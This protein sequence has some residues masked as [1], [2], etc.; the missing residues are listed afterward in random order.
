MI[1]RL[2]SKFR[3][4]FH[5]LISSASA[6]VPIAGL[7]LASATAFA[8]TAEAA[9]NLN[10]CSL[11]EDEA[12]GL[13]SDLSS[14]VNAVQAYIDSISAMLH[15]ERFEQ[16]DCLADRARSNKER[17]PGGMW[18]IHE[19][20]KGL[21]DPAPDKHA[22]EN[23]WHDLMQLL[24]R[25]VETRPQSATARVALASAWIEYAGEARGTGYSNTVS[26]SGWKLYEDRTA[27]AEKT[28]QQA[29]TLKVR[30]PEWYVVMLNLA[31]NQSWEVKRLLALFDEALA[32]EPG[33]YYYGRA[34]AMLLEPKWSGEVGD[35][36]KFMEKVADQMGGEKGDAFYFQVASSK[37]VICGCEDQPQLSLERIER[38]YLA[39]EKE[40][41]VSLLNLNRL[42]YL[43]LHVG[44]TD[45]ALADKT[46]QRIG[47]QWD[48]ATWGSQ[49]AFE[50]T[51]SWASQ[52]L[53][54]VLA[55]KAKEEQAQ[56]N[57]QT[58]EGARYH[59]AFE[60]SYREMLR[61][62]VQSDGA[63]VSSWQGKFE[64]LA[65]VGANGSFED[66]GINS[67]GPVVQCIYQ[68]MRSS[69]ED[70]SPLFPAPPKGSY[71]V[72]IDFDWSELAP[73]AQR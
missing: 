11:S 8:A 45:V 48:K 19:M 42:G 25:W 68:K 67:M 49:K 5:T 55:N 23:D 66:G 33:Y 28:L 14:D 20:Y 32:F 54:M 71:W 34:V 62:C 1:S 41:G 73:T 65:R 31:Q 35:T 39:V 36:A 57:S 53:P 3:F 18:K 46:L 13:S 15:K 12:G 9:P 30:C 52:V 63:A 4:V 40:Y 22:T 60:K 50:Q 72:R 64:T 70:K 44:G 43:T 61:D 2:I 29:A 27:Q 17:F 37:D 59:V 6:A 21:Y 24:Q 10:P 38:G 47:A 51:K 56:A 16:L 69:L 58:P 7:F 26:A